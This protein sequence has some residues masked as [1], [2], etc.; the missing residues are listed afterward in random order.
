YRCIRTRAEL[1]A[2]LAEMQVTE[3]FA[4]DT[5]TT[6]LSPHQAKLCGVSISTKIGTGV[7]IPV[8][9]PAPD[10]H[11]DEATVLNALRPLLED[12]TKPKCGH[13]L[14][15]DTLIF[16]KHTIKF[17]GFLLPLPEGEGW[18]EGPPAHHTATHAPLV[19]PSTI[20]DSM[21]AS[22]LIDSSRSSHSLDA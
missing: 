12:A 17:Q 2:L 4:I 20:F 14:K 8:R 15:Y 7:Y 9:S 5:E 3:C 18:G 10:T 19:A 13:N 16:R 21:V 6:S 1:D 11:M 22:Y